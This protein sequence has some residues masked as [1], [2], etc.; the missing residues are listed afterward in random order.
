MTAQLQD[1]CFF[2]AL[3]VAALLRYLDFIVS[4]SNGLYFVFVTQQLPYFTDH[5]NAL[6]VN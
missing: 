1:S 5:K 4:Y 6:S 2:H 3:F